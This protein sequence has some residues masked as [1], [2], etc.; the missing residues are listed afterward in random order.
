MNTH[1]NRIIGL[2]F[3]AIFPVVSSAL[4]EQGYETIC[5][6]PQKVMQCASLTSIQEGLGNILISAIEQH[7]QTAATIEPTS[8]SPAENSAKPS[9]ATATTIPNPLTFP[10][11]TTPVSVADNSAQPSTSTPVTGINTPPSAVQPEIGTDSTV[12][13]TPAGNT[14]QSPPPTNTSSETTSQ[15]ETT[16]KTTVPTAPV[17]TVSD[18]ASTTPSQ[19]TQPAEQTATVNEPVSTNNDVTCSQN[20]IITV[21][22]TAGNQLFKDITVAKEVSI[23]QIRLQGQIINYGFISNGVLEENSLLT[24]GKITGEFKNLGKMQDFHF[25]G[26]LLQ[27]GILSGNI[28]SKGE[29]RNVQLAANTTISGESSDTPAILSGVIRGDAQYPAYL[30]NV[31]ITAK[32]QISGVR[33]GKGTTLDP[34]A[35]IELPTFNQSHQVNGQGKIIETA[36]KFSGGLSIGDSI[37]FVK[38]L[39][40]SG[41]EPVKLRA[42][43]I[44]ATEHLKQR[45]QLLLVAGVAK[46]DEHG[47]CEEENNTSY[48]IL[49]RSSKQPR[50]LDLYR[51]PN[52]WI[53]QL[54]EVQEENELLTEPAT[55]LKDDNLLE[56]KVISGAGCYY[57]FIGYRLAQDNTIIF[58]TT[59]LLLKV[60]L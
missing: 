44:P 38:T 59:P 20:P 5:A 14:P 13:S 2:L 54:V 36:T 28:V 31:R 1:F 52:I 24:G 34:Q 16:E 21:S 7:S 42:N 17:T 15:P 32:T 55:V 51:E 60:I 11:Q 53:P 22:C 39:T 45:T 19:P 43:I 12:I 50:S 35:M 33:F 27:S 18:A 25:V 40:L 48:Y 49:L 56:N 29:F 30:E 41:S 10:A 26:H 57:F 47:E 3:L 23:S 58:D 4:E 9:P 8:S 6:A 37:D 46:L